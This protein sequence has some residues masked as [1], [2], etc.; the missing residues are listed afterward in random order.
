MLYAFA[1]SVLVL[2]VAE[3]GDKT[4]IIA[5]LL[6]TRFKAWQVMLG[7]T[8]VSAFVLLVFAAAGRVVGSFVPQRCILA[9]SGVAFL[10]FGIFSLLARSEAAEA[11]EA[12]ERAEGR[13]ARFGPVGTVIGLFFLA[14]IGDQSELVTLAL[15]A[16]PAGPL[17]GLGAAAVLVDRLLAGAGVVQTPAAGWVSF[18][19]VWLGSVVGMVAAD[20]IGVAA[21]RLLRGRF[22]DLLLRR[23][24]G[25]VFILFGLGALALAAFG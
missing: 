12:E 2:F 24:S 25:V 17:G 4:Q 20:A 14:E 21:G 5:F 18:V 22:P 9:A 23:I 1:I 8:V 11:Q 6:A 15:A 13:Y 10:G 19:G 7:I 16:N 3:Q